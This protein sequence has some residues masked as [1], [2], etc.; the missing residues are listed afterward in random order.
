MLS[1]VPYANSW[2]TR[3]VLTHIPTTHVIMAT[4]TTDSAPEMKPRFKQGEVVISEVT[5]EDLP[6]LV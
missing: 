5:E 4:T 1:P 2:P 6:S 3:P